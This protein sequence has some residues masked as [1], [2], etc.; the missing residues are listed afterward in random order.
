MIAA[1]VQ[2]AFPALKEDIRKSRLP[3]AEF[4]PQHF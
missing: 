1:K 3:V 4:Q 2:A